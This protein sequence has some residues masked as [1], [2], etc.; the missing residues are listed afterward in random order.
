MSSTG[1]SAYP[2]VNRQ[3][4]LL[5]RPIGMPKESDFQLGEAPV[6]S[7]KDGQVLLHTLYLSV[8]PYMRGRITGVKSYADPI[9]IGQAMIGG[10]VGKVIESK[11]PVFRVGA[12]VEG[13]WEWQEYLVSDGR[14]LH[15][16]DPNVAP[17]FTALGVL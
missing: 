14:G 13:Y 12:I 1:G 7:L 16:L 11:H 9:E 10:A 17:V 2:T 4:K 3:I 5:A 15:K 6:P 8:D